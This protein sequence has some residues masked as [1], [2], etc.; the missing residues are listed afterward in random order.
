M[1]CTLLLWLKYPT[2]LEMEIWCSDNFHSKIF[3][4]FA[5]KVT[6]KQQVTMN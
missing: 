2:T 3:R 5:K 4:K 6:R 1:I